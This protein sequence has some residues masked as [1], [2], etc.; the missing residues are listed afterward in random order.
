M[1]KT[2]RAFLK[3]TELLT[4]TNSVAAIMT[5]DDGRYV[6]QLRD[7]KPHI[8]Y[9]GH[10]GLFGGALDA[11]EDHLYALRREI[12]EELG[13]EPDKLNHFVSL[14]FDLSSIGAK[15]VYRKI[16]ETRVSNA[17]LENFQLGEGQA[18]SSFAPQEILTNL[19]VT[20][21]NSFAIWMHF[22]R[23]RLIPREKP[24]ADT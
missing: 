18:Y 12:K 4:P 11:G 24:E 13:F 5:L 3:S 10:R 19:K 2:F 7:H 15:K 16:Y 14:D 8:F 23:T 21:Y 6:M 9:P 22:A 20:P 17:Q 1:T